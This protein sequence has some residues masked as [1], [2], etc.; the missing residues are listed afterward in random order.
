MYLRNILI[1]MLFILLISGCTTNSDNTV[2][3]ESKSVKPQELDNIANPDYNPK[4][5]RD[6][7]IVEIEDI[8]IKAMNKPLSDYSASEINK[9]PTNIRKK[10]RV[11]VPSDISKDEFKATLIQLVMDETKKNPDIDEIAVFVYDRKEDANSIYTFGK[12]E[13]SPNGNWAGV[14]S[15]IASTNDR[16]TYKYVFD[17]KDK[18]GNID[19][20][21]KPTESEL[22]IF[23]YYDN[24]LLEETDRL[25]DAQDAGLSYKYTDENELEEE[26]GKEVANKYDITKKELDDIYIKVMVYKMK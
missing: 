25:Y 7:E 23:D 5:V 26:I 11:V 24:L 18:V 1:L 8:S 9:L 10:Y 19:D 22:R 4:L 3:S 2:S 12:V 6:Y 13:W 21:D 16:S 17:I 20:S 14:T 15:K